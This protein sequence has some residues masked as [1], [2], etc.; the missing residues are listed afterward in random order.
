MKK[1]TIQIS[2]PADLQYSS[3]I[4]HIADE[5]F[6][7][8]MFDKSWCS[9]LKLIVDELFMNSV[10]YGST[11]YESIVHAT[12]SYDETEV[13]FTMEDDGTGKQACTVQEL[14][15]IIQKNEVNTDFTRTSG[16]GLSM[17]TKVWADDMRIYQSQYGGIAISIAKKIEITA[18]PAPLPP[19]GLVQQ[20]V[21]RVAA[22]TGS[23]TRGPAYEIKLYGE[24]DK[25]NID[26]ITAPINDKISA[27][28]DGSRLVLDFSDVSYINST[29]IGHLA[30][31]YTALHEK[32]GVVGVKNMNKQITE[33]LGLVGLLNVLEVNT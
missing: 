33:I 18:T 16:R 26:E 28:P 6:G 15:D 9:R 3:L 20:A 2:V 31:W 4:R 30:A 17:I 7:L 29:F 22:Q 32:K 25:S 24:I 14:Q 13:S 8:A 27:M 12:F 11:E 19:T 23:T 21:E 10:R 1:Q 5:I